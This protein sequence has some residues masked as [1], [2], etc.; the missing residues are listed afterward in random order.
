MTTDQA[1][2]IWKSTG[3]VEARLVKA[4]RERRAAELAAQWLARVVKAAG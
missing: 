1:Y 4:F 3:H 2:M